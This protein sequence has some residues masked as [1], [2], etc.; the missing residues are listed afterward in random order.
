MKPIKSIVLLTAGVLAISACDKK[1]DNQTTATG[2]QDTS[3]GAG[4]A[5][6]DMNAAGTDAATLNAEGTDASTTNATTTTETTTEQGSGIGD[7][8]AAAGAGAAIGTG[9]AD[10]HDHD[11]DAEANDFSTDEGSGA[12]SDEAVSEDLNSDELSGEEAYSDEDVMEEEEAY[13]GSMGTGATDS[14]NMELIDESSSEPDDV[15]G[16]REPRM[17][18]RNNELDNTS[19]EPDR[20]QM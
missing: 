20:N 11:H 1:S 12:V 6:T 16:G 5:G 7:D 4:T 14:E 3:V 19:S 10:M 18:P 9:A 8:A 17:V 13:P 2:T 15:R